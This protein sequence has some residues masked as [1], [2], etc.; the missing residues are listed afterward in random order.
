MVSGGPSVAS[1][2]KHSSEIFTYLSTPIFAFCPTET[3]ANATTKEGEHLKS[4][5]RGGPT[6]PTLLRWLIVQQASCALLGEFRPKSDPFH[7]IQKHTRFSCSC[8]IYRRPS[9]TSPGGQ[10]T[11]VA[12]QNEITP[13]LSSEKK[14]ARFSQK[15]KGFLS[16][17]NDFFLS[18]KFAIFWPKI[19]LIFRQNLL[20]FPKFALGK[21]GARPQN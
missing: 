9:T 13:S 2:K 14:T 18:K 20:N 8:S 15:K 16:K 4:A 10:Q 12:L 5:Q 17:K 1:S 7:H 19:Y 11:H 21:S 6:A 3:A